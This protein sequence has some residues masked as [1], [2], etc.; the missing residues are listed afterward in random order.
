MA[1]SY[2]L[3]T[4]TNLFRFRSFGHLNIHFNCANCIGGERK[5]CTIPAA[6]A[7]GTFFGPKE[8][9]R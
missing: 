6:T 9:I 5:A 4:L 1:H 8:W 2:P 7:Y 3:L